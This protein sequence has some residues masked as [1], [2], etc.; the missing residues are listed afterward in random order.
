MIIYQQIERKNQ[1]AVLICA[2]PENIPT[3]PPPP[4]TE[5]IR[6]SWGWGLFKTKQQMYETLLEFPELRGVVLVLEKNPFHD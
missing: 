6:I 3:P 5:E 2:V 4:P 1:P